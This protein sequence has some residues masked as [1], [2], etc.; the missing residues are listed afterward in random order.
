MKS[1]ATLSMLFALNSMGQV[2]CPPKSVHEVFPAMQK[3]LELEGLAGGASK[4][5]IMNMMCEHTVFARGGD[6]IVYMERD[7]GLCWVTT[8]FSF[9]NDK[10]ARLE[11]SMSY[12]K[13]DDMKRD[14]QTMIDRFN[15]LYNGHCDME[16]ATTNYKVGSSG[17]SKSL[18]WTKSPNFLQMSFADKAAG[19]SIQ[20]LVLYR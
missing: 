5:A 14:A 6:M 15:W 20:L 2:V 12:E 16:T 19:K 1:L 18:V 10:C 8:I 9:V 11:V 17:V 13:E 3:A 7:T 4:D